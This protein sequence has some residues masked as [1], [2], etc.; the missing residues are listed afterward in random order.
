VEKPCEAAI[1]AMKAALENLK[2]QGVVPID[3]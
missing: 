1:A 3:D 2:R